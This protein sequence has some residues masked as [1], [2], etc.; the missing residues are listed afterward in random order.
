MKNKISVALAL[1]ALWTGQA[2][3]QNVQVKDPGARAT[4]QGQ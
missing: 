1:A 4:V 3:A 2:L